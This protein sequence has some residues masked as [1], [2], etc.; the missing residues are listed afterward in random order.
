MTDHNSSLPG[1]ISFFK[2]AVILLKM[3]KSKTN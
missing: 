1:N 3:D 2:F